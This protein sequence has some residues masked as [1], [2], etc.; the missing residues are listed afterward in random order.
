MVFEFWMIKQCCELNS[1]VHFNLLGEMNSTLQLLRRRSVSSSS[2]L[3]I[4]KSLFRIRKRLLSESNR[5]EDLHETL[6]K[7][8]KKELTGETLRNNASTQQILQLE[9][10]FISCYTIIKAYIKKYHN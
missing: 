4:S 7:Q 2:S 9:Q 5:K 6:T 1:Y 10:V 3:N 8:V